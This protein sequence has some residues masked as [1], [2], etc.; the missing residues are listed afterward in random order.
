[1]TVPN[2][3]DRIF[4]EIQANR[5]NC[6]DF[7][8]ATLPARVSEKL[9]YDSLEPCSESYV[10]SELR[11]HFSDVVYAC[12]YAGAQPIRIA[13]LLEHKSSPSDYPHAQLL[14]YY[15]NIWRKEILQH[16]RPIVVIPHIFY[17][18]R[19]AWHKRS[20]YECFPGLDDALKPYVPS[21]DYVLTDLRDYSDEQI[22]HELFRRD[23]LKV[24]MLFMKHIFDP[25]AI[26]QRLSEFLEA[27]RHY[28]A[29]GDEAEEFLRSLFT[30]LF[31]TKSR[32]EVDQV[33]AAMERIYA[34]GGEIA[35]TVADRLREEGVKWA[36]ERGVDKG[37]ILDKQAVLAHLLECKF[38]I[39]DDQRSRIESTT[40]PA[41]LDA[42]LEKI[43]FAD[44]AD[45]VLGCL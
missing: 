34:K 8:R 16:G 30:Y 28:Y 20:V 14:I 26:E 25:D 32:P 38:G 35:M 24:T 4:R 44:S 12:T 7:L 27:G 22:V 13:I 31:S 1:M 23:A 43:L 10:D 45:E 15:G 39:T 21:F 41:K 3:H 40:E 17:H 18:G 6:I 9:D 19:E 2:P 11:Q 29:C 42:A 33:T 37:R 36:M 5:E